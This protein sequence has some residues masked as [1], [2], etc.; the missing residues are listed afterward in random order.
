MLPRRN[1]ALGGRG[2]PTPCH[3]PRPR[4]R[5]DRALPKHVLYPHRPVYVGCPP[6]PA[7]R[8]VPV[9]V[10]PRVVA[11]CGVQG[12]HWDWV[13]DVRELVLCAGRQCRRAAAVARAGAAGDAAGQ[14]DGGAAARGVRGV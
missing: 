1:V 2:R 8:R 4:H 3:G 6:T 9:A 10:P 5:P 12:W 11:L 13:R 14:A 7:V